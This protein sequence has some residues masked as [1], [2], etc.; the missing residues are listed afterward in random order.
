MLLNC[1]RLL[2]RT[3]F[4]DHISQQKRMTAALFEL[5]HTH[6]SVSLHSSESFHL[7][8][9]TTQSLSRHYACLLCFQRPYFLCF[10]SQLLPLTP[11]HTERKFAG[12]RPLTI[13]PTRP[14]IQT[15]LLFLFFSG[16]LFKSC[17]QTLNIIIGGCQ[18]KKTST[19]SGRT[20]TV[21][22]CPRAMTLFSVAAVYSVLPQY[23]ISLVD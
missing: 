12:L 15:L 21:R 9:H 14:V 11:N 7:S 3:I 5:T 4:N 6:S 16:W 8:S 17:C 13:S 18:L 1:L 2:G 10:S 19:Y 23:W 20:L 22:N